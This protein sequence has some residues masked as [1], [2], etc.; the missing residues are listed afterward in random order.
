VTTSLAALVASAPGALVLPPV[1][2]RAA[3]DVPTPLSLV[4][5]L[6]L[7][8]GRHVG[9]VSDAYLRRWTVPL[10]VEGDAVRRALPGDGVAAALV[11][12]PSVGAP[13]GLDA[14]ERADLHAERSV[15]VD[16]TN[17]SVVVGDRA[18]VKWLLRLPAPGDPADPSARKLAALAAAGF[19][20]VPRTWSLLRHGFDLMAVVT[21]YLP[22]AEDGWT[23]AVEDV[24][25][26]A[27]GEM[28]LDEALAPVVELGR[29]TADLHVALAASGRRRATDTDATD[30]W[31]QSLMDLLAAQSVDGPEGERLRARAA[32]IEAGLQMLDFAAGVVKIDVHGDLHV[33]QWLRHGAPPRYAV[34]DFDGSPV[35]RAAERERR[36]PAARDVA[37]MLASLDHIGRIVLRRTAGAEVTAVR[38]WMR[39]AEDAFLAAYRSRLADAGEG[40]LLD[41][42]LLRP[43]RLQQE[44]RELIYAVRHL[45]LWRYVPDGALADLLPDEPT[46]D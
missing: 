34:T 23:W 41:E 27:R 31:S 22:H 43:M 29:L 25:S 10:V 12:G 6:D 36:Q 3:E 42:R 37:S 45:P 11:R 32:R 44:C 17:E 1:D 18:V 13:F 26:L 38:G 30:W 15:D 40:D 33:G 21:E 5:A 35:V 9:V 46:E 24:R 16:Q 4:D 7:G 8:S 14:W 20:G 19:T 2:R 28:S 39:A